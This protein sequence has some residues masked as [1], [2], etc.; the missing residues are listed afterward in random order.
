MT[1]RILVTGSSVEDM[2]L[3][4]MRQGGFDLVMAKGDMHEDELI[5]ALQGCEGYLL[6]GDEFVT[7][8]AMQESPEL[9]TISFLGVDFRWFVDAAAAKDQDISITNT[10]GVYVDSVTELVVAQLIA[11]RRSF[12]ER[13]LQNVGDVTVHDSASH[14]FSGSKVGIVGMGAIGARLSAVLING[15][16]CEVS[17]FSRTRK[18]EVENSLGIEYKELYDLYSSCDSIVFCVTS[19]EDSKNLFDAKKVELIEKPVGLVN[20]SAAVTLQIDAVIAG[21][22]S[23]KLLYV[24]YDKF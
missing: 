8:K 15:F 7:A 2:L 10:P 4:T 18:P 11:M 16:G 19:G 24:T 6:G 1:R 23:G 22:N 3:E 9:K 21:L 12:Y 14:Q 5:E 13:Q 17:Y 20:I